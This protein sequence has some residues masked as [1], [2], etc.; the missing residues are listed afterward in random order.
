MSDTGHAGLRRALRRA[1]HA[2]AWWC[3]RPTAPRTGPGCCPPRCASR[4]RA[5]PRRA[6]HVK[7]RRAGRDR[8]DREDVEVEAEHGRPRRHHRLL[9]RRHRPL[10]HALRLAAG[11]RRDLDGG[12][13]PGRRPLRP[14]RCGASIGDLA[15]QAGAARRRPSDGERRRRRSPSARRPTGRSPPSRRTSSACAST[16]AWRTSTSWRTRCRTAVAEARRAE[17]QAAVAAAFREAAEI[18]VQ[19]LAPMMPHLAEECW[20]ALGCAGLVAE[21]PWPAVDRALL[22]EDVDHPAGPGER[23][24]ARR[25]DGGARRRRRPR[26]RRRCWRSNAVRRATEGRPVR[27][28]IVVPQRIVNVVA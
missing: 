23:Q 6:F 11:A 20:Q 16:A 4:A 5:G 28:V 17:P 26:S 7:Q 13:R 14:A 27:K 25:R 22:V 15:E 10:V 2:R 1:V 19:L 18:L 8:P 12:G 24:Q 9:R 21:A 3:T